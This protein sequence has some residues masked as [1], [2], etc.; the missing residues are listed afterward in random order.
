[1]DAE[2]LQREVLFLQR[3]VTRLLTV[4]YLAVVAIKVAEFSF[5]GVLLRRSSPSTEFAF[6]MEPANEGYCGPLSVHELTCHFVV[7]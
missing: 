1:M 7:C 2:A 6:S 5:D 3:R 4:L